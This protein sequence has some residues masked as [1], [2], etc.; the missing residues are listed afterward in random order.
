MPTSNPI[1]DAMMPGLYKIGFLFL[2]YLLLAFIIVFVLALIVGALTFSRP[3]RAPRYNAPLLDFVWYFGILFSQSLISRISQKKRQPGSWLDDRQIITTLQRMRPGEFEEHIAKM[4]SGLGYQAKATGRSG[5]GGI[6]IELTK[7]GQL[8]LVQCKKYITRKVDPHDIRDFYGAMGSRH[9]DRG[10]FV[11]TGI[12]TL[13]AERAA[14]S[15]PIELI[16]G[17]HLVQMLRDSGVL[18]ELN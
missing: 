7:N 12:F 4:F 11:T 10:Y 17:S 5:D 15:L 1:F 13:E 9:V 14:E 2:G 3:P 16:Y 6:D 18:G 8:Y